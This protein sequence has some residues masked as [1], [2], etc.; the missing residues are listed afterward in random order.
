MTMPVCT[1]LPT[2]FEILR[3][4]NFEVLKHPPYS[5]DLAPSD[6]HL[7]G[8][9]KDALRGC[10]FASDQQVKEVV[11]AWLVTQS[12]TFFSEGTQKLVSGW[13]KCVA[14]E[15]HYVEK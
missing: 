8:P 14:K 1:L 4:L 13:T 9:L 3:H 6:Y 15:G 7:F 11:H 10:H 5:S 12:K 2:L